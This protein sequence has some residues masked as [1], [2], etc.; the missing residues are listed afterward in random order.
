M[1]IWRQLRF[2]VLIPAMTILTGA[3]FC[4]PEAWAGS[5]KLPSDIDSGLGYLYE[6]AD[7]QT[8]TPFE[9]ERLAKL[10]AFIQTPRNEDASSAGHSGAF[11]TPWPIMSSR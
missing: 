6:F 5:P 1:L 2:S 7:P 8:T 11:L 4:V 3:L 10:L 9:I